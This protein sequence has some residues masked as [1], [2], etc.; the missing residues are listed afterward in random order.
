MTVE[1]M[2]RELPMSPG[3]WRRQDSDSKTHIASCYGAYH[4]PELRD[5]SGKTADLLRIPYNTRQPL[6]CGTMEDETYL[7]R[8]HEGGYLGGSLIAFGS[9]WS[10]KTLHDKS[11]II[12]GFEFGPDDTAPLSPHQ[13]HVT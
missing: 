10:V 9:P 2:F 3:A 13:K 12:S 1:Q 5:V 4:K 8:R 6:I 11:R 7:L